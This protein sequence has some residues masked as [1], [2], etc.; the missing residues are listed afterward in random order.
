[1]CLYK[2][3]SIMFVFAVRLLS[4]TFGKV[5]FD[6]LQYALT[7]CAAAEHD[8]SPHESLDVLDGISS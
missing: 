7:V 6:M 4:L 1:M 8:D 3:R 5:L 2:I